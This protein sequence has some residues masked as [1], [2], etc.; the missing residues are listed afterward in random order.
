MTAPTEPARTDLHAWLTEQ[1]RRTH[2]KAEILRRQKAQQIRD[3]APEWQ[4]WS[5]QIEIDQTT[6]VERW[7]GQQLRNNTGGQQ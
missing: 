4:T 7:L 2:I 5:T 1:Q 6:A 3:H